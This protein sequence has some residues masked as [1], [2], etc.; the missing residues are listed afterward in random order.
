MAISDAAYNP[1]SGPSLGVMLGWT[2]PPA[3]AEELQLD[4]YDFLIEPIR[5]KDL[6][7]GFLFVKRLLEGAQA[8][9]S[10]DQARIFAIKDLWSV[11]Q[12]P[13]AFLKYLKR[14]VGWTKDLDGITDGLDYDTLRRLIASAVP[15]WKSRSTETSI[16]NILNLVAGQSSIVWN[17]FDYRWILDET[18]FEE[19]HQGRDP[20]LIS[21]PGEEYWSTIRIVDPGVDNRQIVKDIVNLMRPAGERYEIVYLDF[22][23][24]F[25]A[26][27]DLGQWH[28]PDTL[29][30]VELPTVEDGMAKFEQAGMQAMFVNTD[31][32]DDWEERIVYTRIR[33]TDDSSSVGGGILGI[34]DTATG[35]GYGCRID[36]ALN[37]VSL[38]AI[39]SWSSVGYAH[40]YFD[41]VGVKLQQDVWYGVRMHIAKEGAGLRMKVYVDGV[42]Y[43]NDLRTSPVVAKGSSGIGKDCLAMDC[44]EFEVMGLPAETDTVE[45]NY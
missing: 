36:V 43:I 31:G 29:V 18:V 41:D 32:A 20:W 9:W 17:W 24:R 34:V 10:A 27:G 3:S 13:D 19:A 26:D 5:H 16:S 37:A 8:I 6:N 30:G 1:L 25:V 21:M 42:E 40:F 2:E 28:V 4:M 14:I 45:I 38:D 15:L 22:L 35:N 23:E 11:T 12:C 39:T 7:E 33:I 44:D